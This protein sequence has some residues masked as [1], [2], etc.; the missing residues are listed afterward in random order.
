[1]E[2]IILNFGEEKIVIQNTSKLLLKIKSFTQYKVIHIKLSSK[3]LHTLVQPSCG[4]HIDITDTV[5]WAW[6]TV[7]PL[8]FLAPHPGTPSTAQFLH[9]ISYSKPLATELLLTP[10]L[11]TAQGFIKARPAYPCEAK[12]S[13]VNT[14][15]WLCIT[16]GN[17]SQF[18]AQQLL[19]SYTMLS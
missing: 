1:M 12:S 13:H 6:F 11:L 17:C 14:E 4:I 10:Y 15:S 7:L 3:A 5:Q 8:F 2:S 18:L 19:T 16:A 9:M